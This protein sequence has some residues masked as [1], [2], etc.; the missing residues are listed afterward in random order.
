MKVDV[1][2]FG[3]ARQ[4]SGG[5][6]RESFEL[7]DGAT[8]N[9]LTHLVWERYP[10]LASIQRQIRLAV[11]EDFAKAD[12]VLSE[13]DEV[14]LIPPVAGGSGSYCV[15]SRDPLSVDEVLEAV[16]QP[17][18]GAIVVFL[19]VVRDH[20]EG[21]QVERLEY[22]AYPG[23][24]TRVLRQIVLECEAEQAGSRVAVAHRHGLLEIGDLA[25]VIAAS[26]PHR[27]EAFTAARSC[28]EKI[29][30]DLPVWKK[31]LSPDGEQWLGLGA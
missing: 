2:Y 8:V 6:R 15:L 12:D 7:D 18:C 13:G 19:G 3:A 23:M 20:N 11:N 14:A 31:E 28:I 30:I 9:Q 26:A 25:V 22:E 21:H 1:L 4:R 10:A 24:V 16:R 29:K 5:A 17:G 27:A